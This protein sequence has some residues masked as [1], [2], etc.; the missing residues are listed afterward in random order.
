MSE[1]NVTLDKA[2]EASGEEVLIETNEPD[3]SRRN[4][5][6]VVSLIAVIV[7][8]ALA[9]G[10]ARWQQVQ[11]D[12]DNEARAQVALAATD[13]A[14]AILSYSPDT[15]DADLAGAKDRLTGDFLDYYTKFTTDVVAPAAKEKNIATTATV[16]AAAVSSV[17][18]ST[19]VVLVFVNQRTT[20]GGNQEPSD[21]A[22][23]VRVQLTDV[24][25]RWLIEKFDPV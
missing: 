13:G 5:I 23:S 16:P 14:V 19:A 2:E 22:S 12:N 17:D 25:G 21:S 9:T 1:K 10:I 20:T 15:V 24:D 8:L 11:A 7:A 6:G 18:G 3:R 4:R